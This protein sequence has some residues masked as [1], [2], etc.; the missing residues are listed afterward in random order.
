M[1]KITH[2]ELSGVHDLVM[3]FRKILDK[4]STEPGVDRFMV[5]EVY[6]PAEELMR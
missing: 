4:F 2:P 1:I 3:G 5:A 6:A